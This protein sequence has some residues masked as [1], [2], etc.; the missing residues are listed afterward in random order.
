MHYR[1]P[2]A[3]VLRRRRREA[4]LIIFDTGPVVTLGNVA[5]WLA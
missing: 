2:K 3:H 4:E 1:P 5:G